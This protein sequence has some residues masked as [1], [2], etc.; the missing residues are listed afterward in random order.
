MTF[1]IF[2]LS[3]MK[4]LPSVRSIVACWQSVQ[5]SEYSIGVL[6]EILEAPDTDA[7]AA[8][9]PMDFN[10]SLSL[11]SVSFRYDDAGPF[12]FKDFSLEIRKGEYVGIKGHSG[13]GKTTLFNLLMG[14]YRPEKGADLLEEGIRRYCKHSQLAYAGMLAERHLG[15]DTVFL[16]AEK[17]AHARAFARKLR[18]EV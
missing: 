10:R 1:G 12:L 17:E 5:S 16:D 14:F 3:A 13:A 15:Y 2:A 11:R 4:I 6:K 9:G 8:A 18:I 7:P